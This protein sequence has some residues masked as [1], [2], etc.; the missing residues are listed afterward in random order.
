[1]V[2]FLSFS[3]LD[4]E[5]RDCFVAVSR[6]RLTCEISARY[7]QNFRKILTSEILAKISKSAF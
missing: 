7:Q 6:V 3:A 5:F 2:Q 1:M 4:R